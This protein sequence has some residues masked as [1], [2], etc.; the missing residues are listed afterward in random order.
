M[1]IQ[2][3]QNLVQNIKTIINKYPIWKNYTKKRYHKF[4]I[5][6]IENDYEMEAVAKRFKYSVEDM[7]Q[8]FIRIERELIAMAEKEERVFEE[9]EEAKR[10][11]LLFIIKESKKIHDLKEVY[12]ERLSQMLNLLI[13]TKD[14]DFT[15]K[16]LNV[17]KEYI[18]QRVIGRNKPRKPCEQGAKYYLKQYKENAS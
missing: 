4:V 11:E 9:L 8:I 13:Q 6:L 7:F 3:K 1:N 16:K 10:K 18:V 15:S 2:L 12:P 14:L 17:G 5:T